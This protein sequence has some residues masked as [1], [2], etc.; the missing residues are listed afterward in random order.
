MSYQQQFQNQNNVY[1]YQNNNN[2]MNNNQMNQ[3]YGYQALNVNNANV[4][5]NSNQIKYNNNVN[6]QAYNNQAYNNQAYNNQAYNNQAYNNNAYNNYNNQQANLNQYNNVN[7]N[8]QKQSHSQSHSQQKSSGYT[9]TVHESTCSS[10]MKKFLNVLLWIV[11]I[12]IFVCLIIGNYFIYVCVAF[13]IL[14]II[15]LFVEFTS[16]TFSFVRN[17]RYDQSMYDYMKELYQQHPYIIFCC[18][19]F[20]YEN[21]TY[22]TKD[23]HGKIISTRTERKKATSKTNEYNMPYYSCKDVSGLFNLDIQA[24]KNAKKPLIKIYL[25]YEINF[26]DEIS[27]YDYI[28]YKTDF[29]EKNRYY[30]EYMDYWE[31]RGIDNF[32]EYNL[33]CLDKKKKPKCLNCCVYFLCIMF[34]LGEFYKCYVDKYCI[35]Q[36][37]TIRKLVS[38]RYNIIEEKKYSQ[39]NPM[40]NIYSEQFNYNYNDTGYSSANYNVVVPT[41]QELNAAKSYSSYIPQYPTQDVGYSSHIVNDWSGIGNV[42]YNSPPPNYPYPGDQPLPANMIIGGKPQV[43]FEH[44][45]VVTIEE[46]KPQAQVRPQQQTQQQTQQQPKQQTQQQPKQ[47]TQQQTQ[48]QPKQQTQTQTQQNQQQIVLNDNNVQNNNTQ[49][50]SE[51][52]KEPETKNNNHQ[53]AALF[54]VEPKIEE[55]PKTQTETNLNNNEPKNTGNT[56][57]VQLIEDEPKEEVQPIITTNTTNTNKGRTRQTRQTGKTASVPKNIIVEENIIEEN[58]NNVN[59]GNA[60]ADLF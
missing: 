19:L 60:G 32:V 1:T 39:M 6:N 13:G 5:S 8:S 33:I 52:N 54:D 14:Y 24:A 36:H 22:I 55:Q 9:S 49:L 27:Y 46:P 3:N 58:N 57:N 47:Q 31:K 41:Q 15:Y 56:I 10:C 48:Q 21:H 53:E 28:K 38:T 30:D 42:D 44:I 29:W 50:E 12:G 26:A 23:Q 11:F 7:V 35:A 18:E 20:H 17:I 37:Y 4:Y 25:K 59:F 2:Y 40:L 16:D 51:I 43:D 34:M 45:N